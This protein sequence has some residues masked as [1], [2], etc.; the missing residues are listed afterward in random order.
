MKVAAKYF[1]PL[2][3]FFSLLFST[4]QTSNFLVRSNKT[5][6]PLSFNNI[7]KVIVLFETDS[8][9]SGSEFLGTLSS[10]PNQP[11]NYI[12]NNAKVQA[13]KMGGNVLKINN[14]RRSEW[15]GH[16]KTEMSVYFYPDINYYNSYVQQQKD[17]IKRLTFGNN[18]DYAI[19]Y[20]FPSLEGSPALPM[21][22]RMSNT[23]LCQVTG[24]KIFQ[25][26]LYKEGQ[27][28][29]R[30]STQSSETSAPFNVEFGNE[31]Y[32]RFG[33]DVKMTGAYVLLVVWRIPVLVLMDNVQGKGEYI[34][35]MIN[36]K[37]VYKKIDWGLD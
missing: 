23:E 34:N 17:S 25:I 14:L 21:T 20:V 18:P 32:L 19:L 37:L 16:L 15:D 6:P 3:I 26:K 31:Y 10:K 30:A 8:L 12:I 5:K 36:K 22:I 11:E 33:M 35:A 4:C 13:L 7:D 2:L 27:F 24:K 29:L 9:L 28:T 1:T